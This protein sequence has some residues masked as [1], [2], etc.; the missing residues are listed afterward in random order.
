MLGRLCRGVFTRLRRRE[1][2]GDR[3][4]QLD[5]LRHALLLLRRHRALQARAQLA[6]LRSE[7]VRPRARLCR[8]ARLLGAVARRLSRRVLRAAASALLGAQQL[9]HLRELRLGG[10]VACLLRFKRVERRR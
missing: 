2:R 6:H 4:L 9:M 8:H 5:H 1:R 10:K 3:P 7:S